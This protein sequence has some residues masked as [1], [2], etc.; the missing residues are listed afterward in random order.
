MMDR[1]MKKKKKKKYR[2]WW[3]CV[4]RVAR[5]KESIEEKEGI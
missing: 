2:R 1:W 3:W 5:A 4:V